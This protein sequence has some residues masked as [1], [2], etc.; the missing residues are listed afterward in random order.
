MNNFGKKHIYFILLLFSIIFILYCFSNIVEIYAS[1]TPTIIQEVMPG[2]DSYIEENIEQYP[3][4]IVIDD[5]ARNQYILYF[6]DNMP[7]YVDVF[8]NPYGLN[9]TT[10]Y[11]GFVTGRNTTHRIGYVYNTTEGW[12]KNNYATATYRPSESD[13]FDSSIINILYSNF[14]G[15]TKNG[16][17]VFTV[18]PAQ[19]TM[20][21]GRI[22]SRSIYGVWKKMINGIIVLLIGFLISEIALDKGYQALKTAL[23]Q[24]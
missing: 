17:V 4:Y 14:S 3:Y 21:N 6:F 1:D 24:A 8:E 13:D 11:W 15:K 16:T 5:K 22:S 19:P 2:I 9:G 12:Y 10:F 23:H 18:T 20:I 7:G